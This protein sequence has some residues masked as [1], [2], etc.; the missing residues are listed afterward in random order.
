MNITWNSILL[1]GAGALVGA[2]VSANY[3]KTKYE[4]IAQEEIDSVKRAFSEPSAE[5]TDDN[6]S[7][8]QVETNEPD[9]ELEKSR[10]DCDDII[11]N[12]GYVTAYVPRYSGR[13]EEK[14]VKKPYV[15]PPTDFDTEDGYEAYS[16]DY[17]EDGVLADEQGNPIEDVESMVGVDSLN[18]FGEYEDYSVHVRNPAL[19]CDFEILRN[20]CKYSDAYRNGPRPENY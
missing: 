12:A 16:L 9:P 17:Y 15:I 1:F 11:E 6:I 14:G 10:E 2:L 4:R 3:F 8:G 18:H 7:N 13:K 19:K 5:S 20:L